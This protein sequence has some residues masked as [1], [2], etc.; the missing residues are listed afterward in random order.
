MLCLVVLIGTVGFVTIEGWGFGRA[1]YFTVI[2]ITT[3]GYGDEGI[4]QTGRIFAVLLLIGG[5]GVVSHS[6]AQLVKT[7]SDT[8][9]VMRTRMQKRINK[10]RDHVIVCGFGR[11]GR[12][13]CE[14][15]HAEGRPFVVIDQESEPLEKATDHGYLWIHGVA[16]EDAVLEAANIGFARN[17]VSAVDTM[18]E[19]ILIALTAR[20]LAPDIEILARAEGP[21]SEAKLLRAGADVVISPLRTG[22][23]QAAELIVNPDVSRFLDEAASDEHD[24]AMMSVIVGAGSKLI[25]RTLRDYGRQDASQVS[26]V[27]LD[28]GDAQPAIPPA[29]AETFQP[30][31]RLIVAGARAQIL[32]MKA[33]A[34][35][36]QHPSEAA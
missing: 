36:A 15:L 22:G 4:S 21:A 34:K 17:I 26:F 14:R 28:R 27:S 5:L 32:R 1:L 29:G 8:D 6:F 33:D 12:P 10:L 7:M 9:R 3:V 11:M 30:G 18:Q 31:D 20:G 16:S 25:G 2:T 24:V 35:A 19:N 23:L 13:V